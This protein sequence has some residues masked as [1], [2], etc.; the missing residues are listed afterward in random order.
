MNLG[1]LRASLSKKLKSGDAGLLTSIETEINLVHS[2]ILSQEDWVWARRR[3]S[4]LSVAPTTA[5]VSVSSNKDTLSSADTNFE[6]LGF[7][8]GALIIDANDSNVIRRTTNVSQYTL[9]LD[10]EWPNTTSTSINI[11]Q[12]EYALSGIRKIRRIEY[13]EAGNVYRLKYKE[14]DISDP[15][16]LT[17]YTSSDYDEYYWVPRYTS[18]GYPVVA[19]EPVP[20]QQKRYLV[21]Y[22]KA[23][24]DMTADTDQPLIPP[25]WHWVLA[26]GS[27]ANLL[28]ELYRDDPKAA[29]DAQGRYQNGIRL[30]RRENTVATASVI[31]IENLD[32]DDV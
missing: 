27:L 25:Q 22:Y 8:A 11:Y 18:E 19:I 6:T 13:N 31:E 17:T 23:H 16:G 9:T 2:E 28:S 5:S 1:Q 21:Y 26:A 24:Q 12:P 30:M 3:G 14:P 7:T 20:D 29:S 15:L 10:A 4:F 32:W